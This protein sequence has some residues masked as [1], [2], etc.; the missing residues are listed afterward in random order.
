VRD[1]ETGAQYAEK[2]F[3]SKRSLSQLLRDASYAFC[4]QAPFPYGASR[5][6]TAAALYRRKVLRDL[7]EFWFGR[8]LVADAF[9]IRRNGAGGGYILG[10]QYVSG[11]GPRPGRF[12]PRLLRELFLRLTRRL[13][14]SAHNGSPKP[15]RSSVWEIDE[16]TAQLDRFKERFRESGF[17]GSEWQVDK[18]LSVPTS[19]LL[20]NGSRDW[21][22]VD[23]ESGLPAL[24]SFRY[25]LPAIRLRTFPMFDDVNFAKLRDYLAANQAGLIAKLGRPRFQRL[26]HNAHQLEHHSTMWKTSE[27]AVLRNR[28]R[29]LVD[30]R[31]RQRVRSELVDS[32]RGRGRISGRT[33][34]RLL[35]SNLLFAGYLGFSTLTAIALGLLTLAQSIGGMIV[36]LLSGLA[37]AGRFVLGAFFNEEYLRRTAISHVDRELSGWRELGRLSDSEVNELRREMESPAAVEYMK[38]LTVHVVLKLADPPFV[39]N[40]AIVWL[41]IYFELPQLLASMFISPALRTIYTCYRALKNWRK[42]ISYRNALLIG[43]L[44]QVGVLAYSMQM[45]G[46]HP[47]LS[48]FLVLSQAARFG[49]RIPLFGGTNSILEHMCMRVA[50]FAAALQYE[51]AAFTEELPSMLIARARQFS[52]MR[53][54][55]KAGFGTGGR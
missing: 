3:D 26:L 19:N 50:D 49:S 7:S 37:F 11:H 28:S 12:N 25:I 29:L 47:K 51:L 46:V 9:Y 6:A 43:M 33:A 39:G 34:E 14:R 27:P 48:R 8:P 32:W 1:T 15:I 21:T 54:K 41:A 22:L 23:L 42:R 17:A 13:R 31:V 2:V 36:N 10:T 52:R 35:R 44:P 24:A 55:A 53:E 4:F 5:S 18:T 20:R 30:P 45:A 16:A 38:G 40:L